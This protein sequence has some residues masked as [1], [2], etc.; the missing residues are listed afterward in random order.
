MKWTT[1]GNLSSLTAP[2]LETE[3]WCLPQTMVASDA[4]N[5][6]EETVDA[7]RLLKLPKGH[8]ICFNM[9]KA[10]MAVLFSIQLPRTR[11]LGSIDLLDLKSVNYPHPSGSASSSCRSASS[12]KCAGISFQNKKRIIQTKFVEW[13]CLLEKN[14]SIF[15]MTGQYENETPRRIYHKE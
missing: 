2:F 7:I 12:S 14:F 9:L 13:C 11:T 8:R 4:T 5:L 15:G 1:C 6:A 10:N 3:I